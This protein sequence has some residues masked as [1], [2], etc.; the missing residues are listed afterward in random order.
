MTVDGKKKQVKKTRLSM[1]ENA[2][3]VFTEE[4]ACEEGEEEEDSQA[5][6]SD[7]E[8]DETDSESC[9]SGSDSDQDQSEDE[10]DAEVSPAEALKG[11]NKKQ[12]KK[13]KLPQS[14]PVKRKSR[15]TTRKD[16]E[17]KKMKM[18][19][20]RKE[21]KHPEGRKQQE[22]TLNDVGTSKMS[23]T[24]EDDKGSEKGAGKNIKK[25]ALIFS[26]KNCDYDL[27]NSAAT[28]VLPKKIKISNNVIVTCRMIDHVE[29][30]FLTYD[31][32]ALTFQR[33]TQNDKMFEFMLPLGLAPRIIEALNI[34]ITNNPKFFG[35]A[36]ERKEEK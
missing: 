20:D 2:S 29:G 28:N 17:S 22:V 32:A 19:S 8:I 6:D 4:E 33:K 9:T 35:V 1:P 14:K 5:K 10:N 36:A 27:F 30:K 31:Y 11:S 23:G 7:Y 16:V 25:E 3:Q 12:V 18:E 13:E 24:L 26:D 34:M 15:E 21:R